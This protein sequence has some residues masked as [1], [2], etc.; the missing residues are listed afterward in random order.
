AAELLARAEQLRDRRWRVT[1]LWLG[2]TL[3]RYSGDLTAAL[4]MTER[5]LSLMPVDP[6]LLWTRA[7][8]ARDRGDAEIARVVVRKLLD[9]VP[10]TPAAPSLAQAA[11]L[12]ILAQLSDTA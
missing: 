12:L 3:A 8:L 6:R 5:G 11:T 2:G 9:T 1:A 7:L 4:D 10:L